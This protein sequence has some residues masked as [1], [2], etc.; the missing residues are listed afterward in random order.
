VIW[1]AEV[2]GG[3]HNDALDLSKL[4][5]HIDSRIGRQFDS[6]ERF[7][8][9]RDYILQGETL[10]RFDGIDTCFGLSAQPRN[11]ERGTRYSYARRN[12][13]WRSSFNRLLRIASISLGCG[14]P[15]QAYTD[16]SSTMG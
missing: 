12:E 14:L 16:V 6:G 4:I 8:E 11:K 7:K 5:E 2:G 10:V 13:S 1:I 3:Q 9:T 15:V